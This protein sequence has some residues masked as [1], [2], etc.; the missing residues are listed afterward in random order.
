MQPDP[1]QGSQS[2]HS[3]NG[4]QQGSQAVGAQY[5]AQ[6][7]GHNGSHPAPQGSQA[8]G[9]S[10]AAERKVFRLPGAIVAW[11]AW[12]VVAVFCL[13]D[14][15]ATGPN[16][17]SAEIALALVLV[18][19][20][21]YA[22]ALRPRVV[23]DAAGITV[24]NPLRDHRIPWGSVT[25]VDSA[26]SVRVHADGGP[27]AK[28]EKVVHSWALYAQRRNRIR[29]EMMRQGPR[30]L[31]RSPYSPDPNTSSQTKEPAAQLM[32]RQL[33]EMAKDARA[34]GVPGGPAVVTWYW[35]SAVAI[36]AP[37]IALVLV[38]TLTH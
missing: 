13:I 35:R 27:G 11:W 8:S 28:R 20:V 9:A 1:G 4:G 29:A 24:H 38:I 12:I 16:H 17:T 21:M 25:S 7:P 23:T 10:A 37:A 6:A 14:M 31:P 15:A 22:C 26:E 19:G 3:P 33:D 2:Q 30:R 36:V 34:R 32:A 5:T 18:T